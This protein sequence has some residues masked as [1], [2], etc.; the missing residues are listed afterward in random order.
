MPDWIGEWEW[1]EA[2]QW[3]DYALLLVKN[4]NFSSFE[5]LWGISLAVLVKVR[6]EEAYF[7]LNIF[8]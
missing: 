8:H 3:F 6:V 5:K 2:G 4:S 1:S 7:R